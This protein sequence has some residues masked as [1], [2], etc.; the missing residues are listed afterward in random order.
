MLTPDGRDES[1]GRTGAEV[2]TA[3]LLNVGRAG[4]RTGTFAIK[5]FE[6][7]YGGRGGGW[8]VR[9]RVARRSSGREPQVSGAISGGEMGD[10]EGGGGGEQ[11]RGGGRPSSTEISVRVF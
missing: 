4:G 8:I 3:L 6:G 5:L 10:E 9:G 1:R 7:V 2:R 11:E